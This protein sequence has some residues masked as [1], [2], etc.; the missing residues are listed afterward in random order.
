MTSFVL[1]KQGDLELGIFPRLTRADLLHA[2]TGRQGGTSALVPGGLNMALHVG[3]NKEDVLSNRRKVASVLGF[4]PS[5]IT[6]CQQVH[7]TTVS[8]VTEAM[9]GSGADDYAKSIQGVDALVTQLRQVPLMLFFADC[10]PVMFFDPVTKTI[11]LAHAGWRGSVGDIALK[12]LHCMERNYKCQSANVLVGIGPSIGSCCFEVD[13]AVLDA[14]PGYVD[15]FRPT[16]PGHWQL[17][18][19]QV[20][21]KQLLGAGVQEQNI[22]CAECC[23]YEHKDKFFSY[24]AEDG[25]TGRMAAIIMLK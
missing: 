16:R 9:I 22:L 3:D 4:E 13:Q 5:R 11:A 12:T 18:L 10:V 6:T 8:L 14:A 20:N 21:K 25:K 7:G 1:H 2:F 24:R 15:C 23:T 19:W 17:D